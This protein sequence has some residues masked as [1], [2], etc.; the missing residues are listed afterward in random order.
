[1][2]SVLTSPAAVKARMTAL[3]KYQVKARNAVLSEVTGMLNASK[4]SMETHNKKPNPGSIMQ[5]L[6]VLA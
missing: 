6:N 5:I 2:A 4:N 1:M 3:L